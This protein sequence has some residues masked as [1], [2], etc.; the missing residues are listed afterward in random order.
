VAAGDLRARASS[1]MHHLH[2][3]LRSAASPSALS[4]LLTLRAL[5]ALDADEAAQLDAV[6]GDQP[7][8]RCLYEEYCDL[9]GELCSA[10]P[11]VAPPSHVFARL[12]LSIDDSAAN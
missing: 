5:D 1:A 12:A 3:A 7:R 10:V 8:A 4:S 2:R 11:H 9:V 6:I